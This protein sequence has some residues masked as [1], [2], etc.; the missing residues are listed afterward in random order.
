MVQDAIF[1]LQKE[2]LQNM[3][4]QY[5]QAKQVHISMCLPIITQYSYT[6]IRKSC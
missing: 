3:D 5:K 1:I 4:T 6:T 2:T